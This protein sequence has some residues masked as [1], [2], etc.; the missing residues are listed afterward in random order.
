MITQEELGEII[1]RLV[2]ADERLLAAILK[3]L[4]MRNDHCSQGTCKN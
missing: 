2:L 1:V 3:S 4:A